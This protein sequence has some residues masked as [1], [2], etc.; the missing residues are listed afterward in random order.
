MKK[1]VA[2]LGLEPGAS[3]YWEDTLLS[4]LPSQSVKSLLI[5][6]HIPEPGYIS[7]YPSQYLYKYYIHTGNSSL[8][9]LQLD[10]NSLQIHIKYLNTVY[11]FFIDKNSDKILT[12]LLIV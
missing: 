4:E 9:F 12:Y 3:A 5:F 10:L 11:V 1:T 8:E 6:H 7:S 2:R